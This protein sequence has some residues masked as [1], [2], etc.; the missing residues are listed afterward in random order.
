MW[1]D[2][3]GFDGVYQ[4]SDEGQVR[5][6][7]K[8]EYRPLKLYERGK[9]QTVCL[10]YGGGKKTYAVH[11]LVADAF[12]QKPEGATEV[13]HKDGD[14]HNNRAE[15]LEW[16]SGRQNTVHAMEVLNHYPFGKP[17]KKVRCMDI[18]TGE[19][20]AEFHSLADAA[21]S[22]GKMSAR[23]GITFCC[24]GYQQTAYG[25]RWEYMD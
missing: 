18:A 12:L 4:V 2:I 5:R 14:K 7:F 17:A 20:V 21:K 16:V 6:L 9:Y 19:T 11:K 13:N 3:E 15:N 24:Q 10:S 23:T 25:Y 22:I 8:D 1:K